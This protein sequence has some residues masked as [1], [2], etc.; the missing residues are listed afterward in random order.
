MPHLFSLAFVSLLID[1]LCASICLT[2]IVHS[3]TVLEDA[4]NLLDILPL[5]DLL[6]EWGC[7]IYRVRSRIFR[8]VI[9]ALI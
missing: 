7:D 4:R 8:G 2:N 5:P 6:C 3:D 1:L 9:S